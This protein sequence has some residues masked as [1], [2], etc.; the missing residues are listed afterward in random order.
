MKRWLLLLV[1]LLLALTFVPYLI[2]QARAQGPE[3]P[4]GFFWR[5]M[6]GV[7]CMQEGCLDIANAK[8]SYTGACICVEGYKGC[9]EPVDYTAFDGSKCGPFCPNSTLVACVEPDA[10][11]PG[12][13]PAPGPGEEAVEPIGPPAEGEEPSA[14]KEEPAPGP[15]EEAVEPVD[16]ATEG[17]KP[18]S[19]LTVSDLVRDLEQFLAGEGVKGPTP[20]QAAA[21]AAAVS[22]LIGAWVLINLLSGADPQAVLAAV[23]KWHL[24]GGTA[25]QPPTTSAPPKPRYAGPI[26]DKIKDGEKAKELL[27]DLKVLRKIE[28]LDPNDPNYWENL[29]KILDQAKDSDRRVKA[30]TYTHKTDGKGN[31]TPG[32][33]EDSL[34]I[35]VEEPEYGP[36]TPPPTPPVPKKVP[37][38][39]PKPLSVEDLY[40]KSP[41]KFRRCQD[42]PWAYLHK[43][44][45]PHGGMPKTDVHKEMAPEPQ[46]GGDYQKAQDRAKLKQLQDGDIIGV[47]FLGTVGNKPANH[48]LVVEG[49]KI[50][51]IINAPGGGRFDVLEL[52]DVH[53]IFQPRTETDSYG[54]TH[55]LRPYRYFQVFRKKRDK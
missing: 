17:E 20:G 48:Y 49:R 39:P 52:R 18:T 13:E 44:T 5:R 54:K 10:P 51:Q 53:K 9:Y 28:A 42:M 3:C 34:V 7:G 2:Q 37:P 8:Y 41:G 14:P 25:P 46:L 43:K 15:G 23:Q 1:G 31:K 4:P 35:I 19:P 11:C 50:Y 21:G 22:A 30:I 40:K 33:V 24:K 36:Y 16:A 12:E 26:V 29:D 32:I 6:S 55:K 47:N 38:A 27:K 45:P